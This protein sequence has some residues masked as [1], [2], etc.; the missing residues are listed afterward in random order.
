MFG[1]KT[2]IKT[3][4][5]N[6]INEQIIEKLHAKQSS[7]AE[8]FNNYVMTLNIKNLM[9]EYA[10]TRYE[11]VVSKKPEWENPENVH[12]TSKLTTQEDMESP[13]CRYWL[14]ELNLDFRYHR[15]LW[16][17]SF[18]LQALYENSMFGK[19]GLGLACGSEPLPSYL[20]SK[21]CKITAG[22]KPENKDDAFQK[23]WMQTGQY[24]KNINDLYKSALVNRED[25]EK[26]FELK[27]LNMNEIG[28]INE[29]YDFVWSICAM[30]HI[31]G[32]KKGLEF[33][34]SSLEILK[35]GGISIHTTEFA[36]NESED[37]FDCPDLAFFNK[38]H[39]NDLKN[40]INKT[41]KF[42]EPDFNPGSLCL[43]RYIDCD[44]FHGDFINY[45]GN[46]EDWFVPHLRLLIFKFPITCIGIIIKK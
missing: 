19:K 1:L 29:K 34:E 43:D 35:P 39:I 46:N 28:K 42:F 5:K 14:K 9:G 30:E 2:I 3:R 37:L 40:R 8:F 41:A 25:F 23:K 15:K 36:L 11:T 20:V 24:T 17:Y 12:L 7:E 27:Y 6:Y 21:G 16:E 32:I 26:N 33:V 38:Q 4:I 13:W 18:V 10:K 44:P 22:D 45:P 31:G